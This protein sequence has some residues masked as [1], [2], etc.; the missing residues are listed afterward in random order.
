MATNKNNSYYKKNNSTKQNGYQNRKNIES[1]YSTTTNT[2]SV[3]DNEVSYCNDFL[4]AY[5]SQLGSSGYF[6]PPQ[7]LNFNLKGINM[8]GAVFSQEEIERMVMAPH[9]YEQE[10]RRL[11]YMFYNTISIYR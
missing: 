11:S 7:L 3:T 9:Q 1:H 5:N 2:P 8:E 6:I 4:K 10:L